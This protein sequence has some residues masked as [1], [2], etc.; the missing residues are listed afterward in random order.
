MNYNQIK[1]ILASDFPPEFK[2]Y[3]LF[4]M[5]LKPKMQKLFLVLPQGIENA[6]SAKEIKEQTGIQ[7][8][9][10]ATYIINIQKRF[11]V[12]SVGVKIKKYYL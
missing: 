8:K 7:T 12:K 5:S 9:N 11:P 4:A 6:K 2:A 1:T 10:I 3:Q